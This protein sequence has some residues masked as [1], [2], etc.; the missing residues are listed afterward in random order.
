MIISFKIFENV[1]QSEKI[2]RDWN[3]SD[4]DNF[5]DNLLSTVESYDKKYKSFL[6]IFLTF[7]LFL[8]SE[9]VL[10]ILKYIMEQRIDININDKKIN[11]TEVLK[12]RRLSDYEKKMEVE[13]RFENLKVE[14]DRLKL[15]RLTKNFIEQNVPGF[16]KRE[17][18][19]K[20]NFNML[21]NLKPWEL[22]QEKLKGSVSL[23]N[24][25]SEYIEY[26]KKLR[27]E[28]LDHENIKIIK[29]DENIIIYKPNSFEA[30]N[31]VIFS[32]WCT[33]SKEQWDKY[34]RLNYKTYVLYDKKD[35]KDSYIL[36]VN[37]DDFNISDYYNNIVIEDE[38]WEEEVFNINKSISIF[39][40]KVKK[41]DKDL[42]KIINN[43]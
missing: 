29:E 9:E 5:Y 35:I 34:K 13:K 33:I 16:L 32:N 20:D 12:W 39:I 2:L 23:F 25:A 40:E 11:P 36:M 22:D 19:E 38:N 4:L 10:D 31:S 42:E 17:I 8:R 37:P 3:D 1:Q 28:G 43:L 24:N 21:A 30:M 14:V 18:K 26:V 41:Y 7:Y 6:S 27:E 15:K